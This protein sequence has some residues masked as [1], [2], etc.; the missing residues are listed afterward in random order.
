MGGTGRARG[1]FSASAVR[2]ADA[3]CCDCATATSRRSRAA[4]MPY[5]E[6]FYR[7]MFRPL[8]REPVRLGLTVLAVALDVAVWFA[9][10]LAGDA[11]AGSFHSSLE[12]LTGDNDLEIIATG[13]VPES[14]VRTLAT[15]PYLLGV[16]PRMEDYAI[17]RESK[18]TLP[19]IGVDLIAESYRYFRLADAEGSARHGNESGPGSLE[20]LRDSA[21]IWVGSHLGKRPGEKIDLSIND[22]SFRCTIRGL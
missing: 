9:I 3:T 20:D 18:Q 14:V 16:S 6:L 10:D 4:E 7:L 21:S 19:L 1:S 8:L 17:V 2:R 22:T 13:G 12:T 15:E 5:L 11:A